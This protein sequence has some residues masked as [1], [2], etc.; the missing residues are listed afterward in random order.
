MGNE[1]HMTDT[2][3]TLDP[4]DMIGFHFPEYPSEVQVHARSVFERLLMIGYT[5]IGGR[6]RVAMV[7]PSKRHVIKIPI[8]DMG[9]L[10]NNREQRACRQGRISEQ[11]I[12]IAPCRIFYADR[13]IGLPLL[14]MAFLDTTIKD[15]FKF[16]DWA[17]SVD[18]LQVGYDRKRRLLAFDL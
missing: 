10:H 2:T 17:F 7:C 11:F 4:A 9:I 6:S 1:T 14:M 18:S 8:N 15:G 3:C 12:P 16:P 5:P 13:S